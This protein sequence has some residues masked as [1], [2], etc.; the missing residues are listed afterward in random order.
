VSWPRHGI[1]APEGGAG[2]PRGANACK[3]ARSSQ[4]KHGMNFTSTGRTPAGRMPSF[5]GG[6]RS[7]EDLR[8]R[9]P[10]A[11][12][13]SLEMLAVRA[14]RGSRREGSRAGREKQRVK[15]L[16]TKRLEMITRAPSGGAPRT[17]R[18]PV[19]QA[20]AGNSS[21]PGEASRAEVIPDRICPCVAASTPPRPEGTPSGMRARTSAT[22][23][24]V[25]NNACELRSDGRD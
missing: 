6:F 25:I 22:C 5:A 24:Q 17:S 1:V 3:T 7:R 18:R 4:R 14:R 9:V 10:K 2:A 11:G 16:P 15:R 21:L 20:G 19:G 8:T 23:R 13:Q 12:A